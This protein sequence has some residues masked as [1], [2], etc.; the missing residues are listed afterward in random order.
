MVPTGVIMVAR[1]ADC[2]AGCLAAAITGVNSTIIRA[3][4]TGSRSTMLLRLGGSIMGL[5]NTTG[6]M[7]M[8][9]AITEGIMAGITGGRLTLV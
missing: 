1:E 8:D 9:M 5:R 4:G 6:I 7:G 3:A 2:W